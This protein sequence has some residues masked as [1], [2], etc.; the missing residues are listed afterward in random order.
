MLWRKEIQVHLP[1][2]GRRTPSVDAVVSVMTLQDRTNHGGLTKSKLMT[3]MG[4]NFETS[5]HSI[6]FLEKQNNY[7][8]ISQ[9]HSQFVIHVM[10]LAILC[11]EYQISDAQN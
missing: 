11:N 5:T 8:P 7:I 6:P 3:S 10:Q 1:Q 9:L 2:V 4:N